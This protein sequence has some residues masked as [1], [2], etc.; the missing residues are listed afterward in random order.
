M[1]AK[2]D[3]I[4]FVGGDATLRDAKG[5]PVLSFRVATTDPYDKSTTWW[6]V[7]LFGNRAQALSEMVT[8]GKMIYATGSVKMRTYTANGEERTSLDMNAYDIQLL[9]RKSEEGQTSG[10]RENNLADVF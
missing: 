4:G 2:A 6:S 9:D 8:K 7:S 10:R 1:G 5:R 3:I